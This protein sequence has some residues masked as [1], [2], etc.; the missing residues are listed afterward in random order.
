MHPIAFVK[1]TKALR[2]SLFLICTEYLKVGF[3][4]NMLSALI[5]YVCGYPT[6]QKITIGTL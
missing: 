4:L 5:H 2:N 6:M 3:E 1:K